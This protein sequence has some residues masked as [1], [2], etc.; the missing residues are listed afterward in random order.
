MNLRNNNYSIKNNTNHSGGTLKANS[1][2]KE[3]SEQMIDV[4]KQSLR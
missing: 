2:V 1:K 4:R 3:A